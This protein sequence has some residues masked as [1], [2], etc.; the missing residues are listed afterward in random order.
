M[1]E[2]KLGGPEDWKCNA[3][4]SVTHGSEVGKCHNFGGN[5]KFIASEL[6]LGSFIHHGH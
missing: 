1:A 4:H 5:G 6:L 2:G 3:V